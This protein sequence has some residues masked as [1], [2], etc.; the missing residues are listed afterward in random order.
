MLKLIGLQSFGVTDEDISKIHEFLDSAR[1]EKLGRISHSSLL[2][3]DGIKFRRAIL[4][5]LNRIAWQVWFR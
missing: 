5:Y 2:T 4:N 1:L 3:F